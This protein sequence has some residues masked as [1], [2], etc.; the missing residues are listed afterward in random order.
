MGVALSM[1]D[2]R[3]AAMSG[4]T[5]WRNDT[6]R[7]IR[8]PALLAD[9]DLTTPIA[10]LTLGADYRAARLLVRVHG[11]PVGYADVV[12]D[13]TESIE[14]DRIL[15]A[16]D[17]D[18][19]ERVL[20]HLATDLAAHGM[21]ALESCVDLAAAADIAASLPCMCPQPLDGPLVTVA[22]CT[23]DRAHLL[24]TTLDSLLCQTYHNL[25]IL[26]VDNAPSDDATE[27]LIR[28]HYPNVRYMCE[29][30]PG[31][32]W[33]RNRAIAEARGDFVAY[34][35][36]DAVAD[37]TWVAAL[38]ATFDSPNVVCV[39]GLVVPARLAT[40]AQELFERFGFSKSFETR[41]FHLGMHA[42]RPGFPFK[43][44]SGTGCNCAFRRNIFEQIGLFD[45][46]LDVGTPVPG[47]GDLDMFARVIRAGYE[48]VYDP[49]PVVFHDHIADMATLIN[50]MGQ[51]ER[52]N[53]A[54]LTKHLLADRTYAPMLLM[55]MCRT[56]LRSTIRGLGAA[57]L[58]RNRPLAM[59]LNQARNF[60]LGPIA[61]Y[62][63]YRI[64]AITR[65]INAR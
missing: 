63:S 1:L 9:V 19:A 59:V 5:Y 43:G 25:D 48:M 13:S 55:Y 61:L 52:S 35:D 14:R 7:W 58:R 11:R 56:Y 49:A 40:P 50:K 29:N 37:P 30:R 45:V 57:I 41:R 20:R 16:L 24:G 54:Y 53:S 44:F 32:D 33:A 8:T 23:R 22:I 4:P 64:G 42:P 27:Q 31:L 62:R 18:T 17:S 36:D 2:A 39:T 26:L 46:H 10:P 21:P 34:I 12:A 38:I 28:M 3:E 6:P 15:A 65:E 60:W 47:G 51:Y